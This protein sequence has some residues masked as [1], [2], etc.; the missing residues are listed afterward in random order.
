VA[1]GLNV[2]YV[3]NTRIIRADCI[4]N[5]GAKFPLRDPK[6]TADST[7]GPCG[8]WLGYARRNLQQLEVT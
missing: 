7:K 4:P 5:C 1:S 3:C 8:M 2:L 6:V